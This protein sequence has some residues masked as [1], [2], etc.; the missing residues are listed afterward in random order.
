VLA[1]VEASF[2][3]AAFEAIRDDYGDLENYLGDGLG[4]GDGETRKAASALSGGLTRHVQRCRCPIISWFGQHRPCGHA[5]CRFVDACPAVTRSNPAV[6]R[7]TTLRGGFQLGVEVGDDVLECR[8]RLL[9][10][11]NLH[12]F[13]PLTGPLRFCSAT[14]QVPPLLLELNKW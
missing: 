11:R 6:R 10:R 14:I 1:R 4:L 3:A 5:G 7:E 12:Q 2:L 13:P 8:N 9:N